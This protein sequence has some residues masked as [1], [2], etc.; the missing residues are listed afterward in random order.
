[1][2]TLS[3]K[4]SSPEFVQLKM[5]EILNHPAWY[6]DLSGTEA[7]ILLRHKPDNTYLLRQ[8][9]REGHFYLSCV[10]R[11]VYFKH[12]PFTLSSELGVWLYR[13]GFPCTAPTLQQ[14]IP[15]IMHLDELE[16]APL[17]KLVDL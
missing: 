17:L 16:C 9:E 2:S 1:M 5:S 13:N 14:F 3:V 12:I 10:Q 6:Q 15:A 7:E 8:G 4:K 11:N